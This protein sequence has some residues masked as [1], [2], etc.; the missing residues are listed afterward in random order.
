MRAAVRF[1][2]RPHR[3]ATLALLAVKTIVSIQILRALAATAVVFSHFQFILSQTIGSGTGLPSLHLGDAG[4]D[5]FFVISG[6][7]MVY[8]AEPLFARARG[9]LTFFVHRAIRIAPI[10]W[11]ATAIYVLMAAAIPAFEKG[12]SIELVAASFFF[13]PYLRPENVVQPVVGQGWTLNY[14]MF[15]YAIFAFAIVGSRRTAV[16]IAS[17]VLIGVV[18]A[19]KLFAPLPLVLAFWS[20]PIILEFIFGMLLAI[21]YR[22]GA[23]LP[24]PARFTLILVSF[25]V[26]F[27]LY[28]YVSAD[29]ALRV[30]TWGIPAALL[31]AGATLGG[32]SPPSRVW[33][34]VAMIGDASYSLYLFHSFPIRGVLYLARAAG[35]DL[36]KSFWPLLAAAGVSAIVLAVAIH[37]LFERPVTKALRAYV[38]IPRTPGD[39]ARP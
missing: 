5:L 14:E 22:E 23:K 3:R 31:M 17:S 34:A 37:Y 29:P 28:Q 11:V 27:A 1:D 20:D 21:A 39:Y 32:F 38:I 10:Y 26:F 12:Y 35:L 16:V 6:F 15:F 4:V 9:P 7:V 30:I 18:I 33:R 25:L 8:S 2:A 36:A 13:I 24:I 19:G